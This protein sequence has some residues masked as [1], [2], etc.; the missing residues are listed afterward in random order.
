MRIS[1][2][3]RWAAAAVAA[4][5]LSACGSVAVKQE[6]GVSRPA[7][8]PAPTRSGPMKIAILAPL[9]GDVAPVGQQLVNAAGIA[10][11]ER[12][13]VQAELL[14]FDT[15]GTPQGAARAATEAKAVQPDVVLGP[16]FGRHVPIVRQEMAGDNAATLA[17]TNDAQQAGSNTFAMGLSVGAQ[18]E[19][20][21]SF[22]AG[23]GKNRLIVIGPD[24][25]YTQR[26]IAAAKS[27]LT[28]T[29]GSLVGTAI[30]PEDA[31]F[32]AISEQVQQVTNYPARRAQWRAYESDL[33]AQLRN[34]GNPAAFLEAEAGRFGSGDVRSKMLSGMAQVYRSFA[35][36]GRN[37]ALAETVQ[38][39]E[40][41]DAMPVSEYDAVLLPFGDDNLVAIGSMLD[42]FNAGR[43]FAQLAGTSVW[44]DI[45]LS[46]EPSLIGGWFTYVSD[47]ALDQFA[48]A[49]RNNFQKTPETIAVLGYHGG[50]VALE[51]AEENVRPVTPE[52]VRRSQGFS[53]LAGTVRFGGDGTMR[54]PLSVYEVTP[55]GPQELEGPVRPAS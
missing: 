33:V 5:T 21:V 36:S 49:Y 40:G 32:N 3:W 23:E 18:V 43:G 14:P 17:F 31:D 47:Q 55:E 19:R 16:L 2:F 13:E 48:L 30:Y 44:R 51:A 11:F 22:L 45:E 8:A 29:G 42:L 46:S 7:T 53:G 54:H 28:M 34:A 38:R 12:P 1:G 10:L 50:M 6:E 15:Q 24:T 26:A 9:S 4:I 25:E 39:I 35:S 20:M 41:V 37:R 52:F 27:A